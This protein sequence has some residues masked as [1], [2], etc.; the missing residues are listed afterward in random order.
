MSRAI[1]ERSQ[2]VAPEVLRIAWKAQLRLHGRYARLDG[3]GVTRQKVIT[4]IARELA[5]FVWAI[6]KEKKLA[7]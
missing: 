7:A 1:R 3:R 6:A 4:A 2:G 5:G